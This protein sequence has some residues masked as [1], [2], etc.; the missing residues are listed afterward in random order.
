[1]SCIIQDI[2]YKG[3]DI[4]SLKH[5]NL[6]YSLESS[7]KAHAQASYIFHQHAVSNIAIS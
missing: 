6:K 7:N 1:M 3:D 5:V 4:A 2:D